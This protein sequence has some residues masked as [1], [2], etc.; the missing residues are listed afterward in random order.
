MNYKKNY[1]DY[2]AYVKTLNRQKH[3]GI[4]YE[5]HHI[6]PK[7][8]GG[9]DTEDNLVLLTARE[10]FLA[11]YLLCKFVSGKALKSMAWAFH[12]MQYSSSD[13][14]VRYTNSRLY[15][16]ARKK[17]ISTIFDDNFK[18][19]V[20]ERSKDTVWINNG[21]KSRMIKKTE[22]CLFENTEWKIGRILVRKKK[23]NKKSIKPRKPK[24]K[25]YWIYN[26]E[27]SKDKMVLLDELSIYLS[28]GWKRGRLHKKSS[29]N[30]TAL[31][32]I[33]VVK[34]GIEKNILKEELDL[35]L[36][37]GWSRGRREVK[38]ETRV[39]MSNSRLDPNSKTQRYFNKLRNGEV[40]RHHYSGTKR[41]HKGDEYI[42][43]P[44][45]S[46]EEYIKLGYILGDKPKSE[47]WKAKMKLSMLGNTNG[48]KKEAKDDS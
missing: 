4:Y 14:Q 47:E 39:K 27:E 21:V 16:S 28:K 44:R 30:N 11:H 19:K 34:D 37:N 13:K 35:Y 42:T 41:M 43:V 6:L 36:S 38:N 29:S 48:K 15:E 26:N 2:I 10:H 12:R 5:R 31:G 45:D 9:Q 3:D 32:R 40:K 20:S 25:R 7:S 8:L 18:Q 22:L 17:F 24:E 23:F 1:Y 46:V 33:R